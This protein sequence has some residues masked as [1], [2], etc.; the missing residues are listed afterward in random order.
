MQAGVHRFSLP[1]PATFPVLL[2]RSRR[3]ID[4]AK[5][6]A[7]IGKT[8]G[9]GLVND[10]TRGYLSQSLALADRAGDGPTARSCPQARSLHLLGWRGGCPLSSLYGFHRLAGHTPGPAQRIG[11]WR[12]VHAGS[13][14]RGYRPATADRPDGGCRGRRHAKRVASTRRKTCISFRS[15]G[16]PFTQADIVSSTESRPSA[17]NR[18]SGQADGLWPRRIGARCR[19]GA[20]TYPAGASGRRRGAQRFRPVFARCQCLGRC[21]GPMQRGCRHRSQRKTGAAT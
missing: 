14:T 20:R 17:G 8:H 9:N 6:V 11:D 10:Y 16:R 19:Q 3:V 18:Q 1:I 4:P 7:V 12:G 13:L 15:R 2:R 5:I 21:R